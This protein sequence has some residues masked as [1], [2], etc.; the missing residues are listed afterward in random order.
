MRLLHTGDWHLGRT[1]EGRSRLPEQVA[2]IEELTGIVEEEKIDA[3]LIAGDIF[4]T[5]NP[6][7][8]AEELFY[9][10]LERLSAGGRRPIVVIAGNHD[11]PDR[12]AAAAPLTTKQNIYLLG[13][14]DIQGLSI[15][16]PT[17]EY[18]LHVAPMPYPSEARLKKVLSESLDEEI[19]QQLYQ[20]QVAY[21]WKEQ[22][23]RLPSDGVH[24]AMGH[25]F[26]A[27]GEESDSERPIQ[28]GG[29]Y[30]VG[31][32]HLPSQVEYVALGHLHRPQQLHQAPVL[33]RYSGSPLAY[34]FSEAAYAK[35]VTIVNLEPQQAAT[36]QE[37]HLTSGKPLVRWQAK[38]GLQQV[39]QWLE[40]KKDRNA[41]VD[42]EI[43]L[44]S[45]LTLQEIHQLRQGHEGLIH[46]RPIFPEQEQLAGKE[47]RANLPI[48]ELFR[49]Y[50]VRQTGGVPD[51]A[52]VQLFLS[53]VHEEAEPSSGEAPEHDQP[54]NSGKEGE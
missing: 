36:W 12:L 2:F 15:M 34:S 38:E 48:E 40:E 10:S 45:P 53:L 37:I 5:V 24:V 9:H 35:S 47:R 44:Q 11:H 49:R 33:T 8:A 41:W 27:G 29:A 18:P 31:A 13:Y 3:I 43:H 20:E 1:L 4:D 32:S 14:P 42:L 26:V 54:W 19:L 30:T 6:P 16:M 25:L 46:I 7:A 51:D 23:T 52:L 22:A 17:W 21:L 28:I 39:Q 50:Y